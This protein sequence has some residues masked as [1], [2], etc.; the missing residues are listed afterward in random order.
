ME[1]CGRQG[2]GAVIDIA[3]R[4]PPVDTLLF[5]CIHVVWPDPSQYNYD[6]ARWDGERWRYVD[7]DTL[8]DGDQ[9]WDRVIAWEVLQVRQ[10]VI[11]P[12][13]KG[14]YQRKDEMPE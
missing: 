4:Q 11:L 7:P 12:N 9:I 2:G 3:D 13:D 8:L 10:I 1:R 6:F 5:V 14:S